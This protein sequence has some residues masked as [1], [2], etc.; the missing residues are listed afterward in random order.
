MME[1]DKKLENSYEMQ[2][3][4]LHE[5]LLCFILGGISVAAIIIIVFAVFSL[6][7]EP[8]PG[9][10]PWHFPPPGRV[11][12]MGQPDRPPVTGE[13]KDAKGAKSAEEGKAVTEPVAEEPVAAEPVVQVETVQAPQNAFGE[14]EPV[15]AAPGPAKSG[16]GVKTPSKT[17]KS[18]ASEKKATDESAKVAAQMPDDNGLAG[19]ENAFKAAKDEVTHAPKPGDSTSQQGQSASDESAASA[20][21]AA[22]A[23]VKEAGA[24]V[25][26]SE[27]VTNDL[28][29]AAAALQAAETAIQNGETKKSFDDVDKSR[30]EAEKLAANTRALFAMEDQYKAQQAEG[31]TGVTETPAPEPQKSYKASISVDMKN[32]SPLAQDEV[33]NNGKSAAKC[34]K[35]CFEQE[36]QRTSRFNYVVYVKSSGAVGDV[37]SESSLLATQSFDNCVRSCMKKLSFSAFAGTGTPRV[38]YAVTVT[39]K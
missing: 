22:E 2:R 13:V 30:E 26:G 14:P 37:V 39:E 19:L 8:P 32:A 10:G 31:Q 12:A 24:K 28:L 23:A 16:S 5:R 7:H 36:P 6:T 38:S 11:G 15:K 34:V 20:L 25:E 9:P 17:T 3:R 35:S 29:A 18:K 27:S 4:L 21:A 33:V 1:D